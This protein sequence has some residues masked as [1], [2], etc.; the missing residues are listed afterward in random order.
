VP[1]PV[2]ISASRRTDIPA[3]FADWFA[4]SLARGRAEYRH[5]WSGRRV[6]VSLRPGDTAAFVFWTRDP[7]PFMGVLERLE[8]AGRP[9][10][11]HVTVTGLGPRLEPAAPDPRSAAAA[12]RALSGLIGPERVVWRFDPILPG[13]DPAALAGRFEALARTLAGHAGRCV[14]SLAQPYRKSVRA[15]RGL[16]RVWGDPDALRPAVERIAALGR[17]LGFDM[18][19]CCSP[20]LAAWGLPPAA[21]VD[22]ALL[23][24]LFPG[25]G[26]PE[27]KAPSRPGCLCSASVD[28]GTYRTCRHGCLYCYAA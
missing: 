27:R 15:T 10:L 9:S 21:C 22:G 6:E 3:F 28:I 12:V 11:V 16:D 20:R 8:R 4:E 17:A 23:A 5:P 1:P 14:A 25:A 2:V 18:R 24:R 7:R 13:E 19:S 26:I